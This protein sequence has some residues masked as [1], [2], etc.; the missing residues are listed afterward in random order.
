[1][2]ITWDWKCR[3]ATEC[4]LDEEGNVKAI[5]ET[6]GGGNCL[7]VSIWRDTENDRY[8]LADFAAD[9]DHFQRCRKN[10]YYPVR[11]DEVDTSTREG[12]ALAQALDRLKVPH[13]FK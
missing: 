7:F 6:Y 4:D 10:T 3:I 2:A 13:T 1:M 9:F 5:F 11:F 8:Y 12:E